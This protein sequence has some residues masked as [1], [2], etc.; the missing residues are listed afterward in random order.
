VELQQILAAVTD[1]PAFRGASLEGDGSVH[2]ASVEHDSRLVGPGALFCCVPGGRADGHVFAAAAVEQGAVALLCEHPVG[3]GV[4]ELQVA[5]VRAAMGPISAEVSGRPSDAL[6]VVGI[7]GTNGKTTTAHL[8]RSILEAGGWPTDVIGTLTGARTTPEAPELQRELAASLAAGRRA[9]AMEVSSHAL[10][11]HRVDGTTFRVSVFTN[12][13]RDHLDFHGT[14]ADYFKAKALLFEPALSQ[15]AVVNLDDPNG[16]LLRDAA[17]IPTVG[18]SLDDATD[19]VADA[20]GTTLTWRGTRLHVPLAG[21]FNVENALAAATA[22]LEL[23]LP[24]DAV[25]AGLAAAGNVAGRFEVVDEGQPFLVVVDYAHTPDGLA[26]V[27]EAARPLAGPNQVILVFGAGGNRDR[28]KRPVMGE[29]ASQGADRVVLTS[30]NPRDEDPLAIID[31][32]KDGMQD[33]SGLVVEPD[34]RAAIAE[35]LALAHPGDVVVV[36]GKGHETTQTIGTTVL[37]FDDRAV[38]RELLRAPAGGA[39]S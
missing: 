7:T 22:A 5:S 27:L 34:R 2:V 30:D 25:R 3:V 6:A 33:T 37:P 12:L 10:A 36:A 31:A 11:Q 4:P 13:S 1:G 29:M 26:R 14:M 38:A 32:V 15:R 24:L 23:G 39:A 18:Y 35:A 20:H 21:S 16:R 9:V 19:L 28:A 17:S 8:L